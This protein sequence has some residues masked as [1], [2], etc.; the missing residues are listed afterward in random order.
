MSAALHLNDVP[1]RVRVE[2]AVGEEEEEA[3]LNFTR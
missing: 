1:R 3:A 2:E